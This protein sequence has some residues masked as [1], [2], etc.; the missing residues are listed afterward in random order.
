MKHLD[1]SGRF[2]RDLKRVV[3]R[4]WDQSKL[5]AIITLLRAD[6]PLP[7][8]ARPHRLTGDWKGYW[9]CHVG[10]DWL[11]IYKNFDEEVRLARTGTHADLFE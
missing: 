8:S 1:L 9:E 10:P 7:L 5:D 3:K 2:R 6:E 11:L 4:R